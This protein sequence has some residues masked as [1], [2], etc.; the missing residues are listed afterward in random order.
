MNGWIDVGHVRIDSC[1]AT[2]WTAWGPPEMYA[3]WQGCTEG[4]VVR[5]VEDSNESFPA[6]KELRRVV[7][8]GGAELSSST[9]FGQALRAAR[10]GHE[11]GALTS[12]SCE[13]SS[14]TRQRVATS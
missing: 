10:Y 14:F 2:G 8:D 11:A 7:R 5:R 12:L 9:F 6:E 1:G 13:A 4:S 3:G